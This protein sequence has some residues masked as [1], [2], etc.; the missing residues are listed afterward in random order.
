MHACIYQN[1]G[2]L[3]EC[4]YIFTHSGP[5]YI[6]SHAHPKECLYTA[7]LAVGIVDHI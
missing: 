7:G 6:V 1:G 3:V 4:I 2:P 5:I